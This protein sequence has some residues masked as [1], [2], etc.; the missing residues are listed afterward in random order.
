MSF[1]DKII[2]EGPKVSIITKIEVLGFKTSPEIYKILVDFFKDA[3]V[4]N[5]TFEVAEKTIE[6]RQLH[7]IKLPDA[8]I[9]ATALVHQ[10]DYNF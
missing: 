4:I 1:M 3:T 5:L 2:N 10:L 7:K 9:S 6:L 8:I